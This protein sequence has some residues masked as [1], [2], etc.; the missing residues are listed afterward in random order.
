MRGGGHYAGLILSLIA[1]VAH[2]QDWKA[3]VGYTSLQARLGG[4]TPTGAG[5]AIT[6]I[7]APAGGVAPLY[8][9]RPNPAVSEFTGK[10]FTLECGTC[11]NTD[12][13]SHAT[14]VGSYLY[15]NV[16]SL[17]P[18]ITTI[19]ANEANNWLNPGHRIAQGAKPRVDRLDGRH[20][21][22]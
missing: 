5:I 10:T 6:Q 8:I 17:A 3:D 4:A 11:N 22:E 18:G 16:T 1:S 9:Y 2:A 15:G 13:S 21:H 7:E 12:T 20:E 19:G 14:T